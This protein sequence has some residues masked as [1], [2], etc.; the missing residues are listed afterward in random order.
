MFFKAVYYHLLRQRYVILFD[1]FP[2]IF[3]ADLKKNFFWY[4]IILW[5]NCI[6]SNAKLRFA[7]LLCN[8]LMRLFVKMHDATVLNMLNE[9]VHCSAYFDNVHFDNVEVV[10]QNSS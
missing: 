4:P 1:F 6:A 10:F 9:Y 2:V 5:F 7:S 3:S 8:Y